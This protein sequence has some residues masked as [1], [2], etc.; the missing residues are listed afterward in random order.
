MKF[1][2]QNQNKLKKIR[3]FFDHNLSA[4][5]LNVPSSNNTINNIDSNNIDSNIIN[6]N[7]YSN[8]SVFK[9]GF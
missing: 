1:I 2:I 5:N 9:K 7:V 6:N 3:E 4:N 8:F